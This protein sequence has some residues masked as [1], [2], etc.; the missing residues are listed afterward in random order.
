[1]PPSLAPVLSQIDLPMAELCAARLDGELFRVDECFVPVDEIEQPAHRALALSPFLPERLIAEQR[2]AAWILGVLKAAPVQHQFCVAIGAR[3]RPVNSRRIS[4]REVVIS[5]SEIVSYAGLRVTS[6][7]RTAVDLIRSSSQFGADEQQLVHELLKLGNVTTADC[8]LALG[9]RRNL[10]GKRRAIERLDKLQAS[11]PSS[12]WG[13]ATTLTVAHPI[14]VVDGVDAAH[15]VEHSFQVRR[16]A[17]FEDELA[18]RK[19][20]G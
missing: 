13:R 9:Q 15:R 11:A 20:I 16:V 10:P 2:T 8:R 18:E 14:H 6:P 3:A 17:H 19:A 4:I 7:L 1:M 5:E 12:R